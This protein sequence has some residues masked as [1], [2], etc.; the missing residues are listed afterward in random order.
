MT[1]N[2]LPDDQMSDKEILE[3]RATKYGP[4]TRCFETWATMCEELNK[5]ANYEFI[6]FF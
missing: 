6:W 4:A 2:Q 1:E 5:Y 3:D